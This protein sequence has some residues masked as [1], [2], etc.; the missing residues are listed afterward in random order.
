MEIRRELQNASVLATR[1][2]HPKDLAE[3]SW[4]RGLEFLTNASE[5]SMPGEEQAFLSADDAKVR[6]E[7]KPLMTRTTSIRVPHHGSGE[8]R[9]ILNLVHP[10]ASY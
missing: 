8:N 5:I 4:L 10:K 2:L 9:K 1:S 3:F 7:L 6:K